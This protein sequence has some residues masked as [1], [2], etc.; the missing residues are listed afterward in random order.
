MP[1]FE[2]EFINF[3]Q[4]LE[5]N[6][7]R[8]WFHANKKRYET[9]VK[10]PFKLFVQDLIEG[11]ND[12][13]DDIQMDAKDAIFRINRDI[14]FS[15]DKSP[16]KTQVSALISAGGKKSMD[17]PGLYVEFNANEASIY[18]GAY[19]IEKEPLYS[20]REH[21]ASHPKEFA[22][23]LMDK[24]FVEKFGEIKGE[25]NKRIPK[26]FA[27]AAETQP[28]LF[29]KSFYYFAK[30]PAK[31]IMEDG[32]KEKVLEYYAAT[33]PMNTFILRGLKK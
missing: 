33:K 4:E 1:Y 3:F 7:H 29:N 26:E 6:N 18:S 28:L 22:E 10:N 27:E 32:W 17:H 13:G 2:A 23:L 20:L 12:I 9:Y 19:K 31:A 8:D 21:I 5:K 16:Y 14:R 25:K 24:T 30:F 11:L 15:K